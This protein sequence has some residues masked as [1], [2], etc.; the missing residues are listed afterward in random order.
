MLK[1]RLH[2]MDKLGVAGFMTEWYVCTYTHIYTGSIFET[3][4]DIINLLCGYY[5]M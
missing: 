4:C 2:D 3:T 1:D 5:M